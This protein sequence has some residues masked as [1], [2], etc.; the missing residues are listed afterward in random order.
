MSMDY[1]TMLALSGI[2]VIAIKA[3][4][5]RFQITFQEL[6]E[7]GLEISTSHLWLANLVNCAHTLTTKL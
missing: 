7:K 6:E 3:K 5:G 4:A 1:T 2:D